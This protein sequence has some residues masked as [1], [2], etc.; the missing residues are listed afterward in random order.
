MD[1]LTDPPLPPLCTG[2]DPLC[3]VQDPGEGDHHPDE[4]GG[5]ETPAHPTLCEE[6]DVKNTDSVLHNHQ[7]LP[8]DHLLHQPPALHGGVPLVISKSVKMPF[9]SYGRKLLLDFYFALLPEGII[10][11]IRTT[12]SS[13]SG[14]VY[15]KQR[16]KI[17]NSFC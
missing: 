2:Q 3:A 16:V 1:R 11:Q 8:Q 9:L 14:F 15:L 5:E 4:G 13:Y 7:L 6:G 17:P 12:N 10:E